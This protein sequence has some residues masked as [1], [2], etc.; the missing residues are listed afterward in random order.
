MIFDGW[1]KASG[2]AHRVT[3]A[4]SGAYRSRLPR[5]KSALQIEPSASRNG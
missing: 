2:S 5:R 3:V 4:P 1:E